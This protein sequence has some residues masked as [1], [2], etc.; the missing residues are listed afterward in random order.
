MRG[1]MG[2]MCPMGPIALW[3]PSS[4]QTGR[5]LCETSLHPARRTAKRLSV[6]PTLSTI[7]P[8]LYHGCKHSSDSDPWSYSRGCGTSAGLQLSPC[9]RSRK[10]NGFRRLQ[11]RN[12]VPSGD[13]ADRD[14]V[15]RSRLFLERVADQLFL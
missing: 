6:H 8:I 12:D 11:S 10:I 2:L 5:F 15:R 9:H 13:V 14:H 4:R 3:V 7:I 1:P